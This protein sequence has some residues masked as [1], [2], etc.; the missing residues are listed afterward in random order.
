M[1]MRSSRS[2]KPG[3]SSSKAPNEMNCSFL[4][5]PSITVPQR[6]GCPPVCEC[7]RAALRPYIETEGGIEGARRLQIGN[8]EIEAVERM[9]AELSGTA[10]DGLHERTDWVMETLPRIR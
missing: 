1:C 10:P 9:H 7:Q 8:R 4:R 3:K 6:C 2:R 5:G